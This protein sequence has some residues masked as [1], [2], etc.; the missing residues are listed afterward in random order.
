[1]QELGIAT[2][3]ALY[4][5][6]KRD[7]KKGEA[8]KPSEFFYHQPATGGDRLTIRPAACDAFFSLINDALMPGWVI[9][10]VPIEQLQ[11]GKGT[12]LV[13]K[14]RAWIGKDILLLLPRVEGDRV[15]A[16]IAVLDGASGEVELSDPDSETLFKIRIS[17]QT[18]PHSWGM[19]TEFTLIDLPPSLAS[20]LP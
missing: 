20:P 4:I 3:T 5:N 19:D 14:P 12:G 10:L 2:L 13:P 17:P 8:A 11:A 1:M 16:A 18:H 9:P 15:I 6:S 7:P